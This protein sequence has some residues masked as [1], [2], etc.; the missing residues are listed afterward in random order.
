MVASG[1]V[2]YTERLTGIAALHNGPV[3]P[4]VRND[5]TIK[6][7]GFETRPSSSWA[8][9]ECRPYMDNNLLI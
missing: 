1:N 4:S 3:G 8:A 5:G 7:G 9:T 6:R 2:N